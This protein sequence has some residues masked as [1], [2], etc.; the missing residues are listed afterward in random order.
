MTT[1][2]ARHSTHY[3][4]GR[5]RPCGPRS[6]QQSH[7]VPEKHPAT[8]ITWPMSGAVW[9]Q[10]RLGTSRR[11]SQSPKVATGKGQ[12]NK[13]PGVLLGLAP[14]PDL[15]HTHPCTLVH[16]QQH[17]QAAVLTRPARLREAKGRALGPASTPGHHSPRRRCYKT[18]CGVCGSGGCVFGSGMASSPVTSAGDG[19][20]KIHS[21]SRQ[22]MGSALHSG[23]CCCRGAPGISSGR[24][25]GRGCQRGMGTSVESLLP[26]SKALCLGPGKGS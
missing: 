10:D 20:V 5:M 6:R 14:G 2:H 25:G 22:M 18:W 12:G 9:R 17:A 7:R 4:A 8:C 15:T 26:S 24:A 19:N 16:A 23:M 11:R 3:K 13:G 1:V 21:S